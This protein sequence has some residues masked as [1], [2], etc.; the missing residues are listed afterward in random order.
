MRAAPGRPVAG[1]DVRA[2]LTDLPDG[3][4]TGRFSTANAS[5]STSQ[6]AA[7]AEAIELGAEVL[8]VD[9]DS[10]ATNLLVR[11]ARMQALVSRDAEPIT[12]LLD[13]VRALHDDLGVSTV[14]VMG[15]SGDYLDVADTVIQLSGY[16]PADVTRRAREVAA[17]LPT[18]RE[19]DVAD[20]L[21]PPRPRHLV[22]G[23]VTTT[24]RYGK[25]S[26][27]ALARDRILLGRDEVDLRDVADAL[28]ETAQ[29]TLVAHA[30]EHLAGLPSS[31]RPLAE[32]VAALIERLD[33][34]GLDL[35]DEGRRGRVARVR[36]LDIGAALNRV[37]GLATR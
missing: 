10:S 27:R 14:L 8:L 37:R 25:R 22:A 17:A 3:R 35:L 5:G 33:R 28:T 26:V 15:G 7:I 19:R 36:G 12:V 11:D 21:A 23:A 20:P 6:A 4:D 13:R 1:V 32:V 18:A 2:F 16:V 34:E 9:E 31:D 30:L 24:N 29:T